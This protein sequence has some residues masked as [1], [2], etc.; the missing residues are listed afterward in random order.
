MADVRMA[1]CPAAVVPWAR[2]SARA[3]IVARFS[4][5]DAGAA[6]PGNDQA[7]PGERLHSVAYNA[8]AD[9]LQSAQLGDRRQFVASC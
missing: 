6:V 7:I 8:C 1:S 9:V 5:D 3:R 2:P 4:S